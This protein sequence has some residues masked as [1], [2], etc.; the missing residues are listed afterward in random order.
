M[1][2]QLAESLLSKKEEELAQGREGIEKL[3]RL[4]SSLKDELSQSEALIALK[5]QVTPATL[6]FL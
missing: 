3:D 5:D 4:V 2:L 6:V 1:K